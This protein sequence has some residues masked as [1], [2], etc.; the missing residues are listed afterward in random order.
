MI[1]KISKSLKK[2]V[3][4]ITLFV[5]ILVAV[6]V[7]FV[8]NYPLGYQNLIK[9]H[10]EEFDV[11]PYLVAAIINV[12]SKYDIK[13]VSNKD[14]R[15]LMQ[16]TPATGEWAAEILEIED[17]SVDTLHDPEMNIRIGTWYLSILCEEFDNNLQ[18]VLAAYNA[19]SGNVSKWLMNEN[20]SDDGNSLKHI[21]FNETKKY[22]ERVNKNQKIYRIL[23]KDKFNEQAIGNENH[24]VLLVN[25]LRKVIKYLAIFK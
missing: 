22:I 9:K 14:A 18:L 7:Y 2:L 20:Y 5:L 13:A 19:G 11:D 6:L 1:F 24:V 12:E 23:Y 10:S 16:I 3:V 17:Y 21:P 15:G 8:L 25:N 4:T